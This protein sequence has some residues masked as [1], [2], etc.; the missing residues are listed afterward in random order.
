MSIKQK[1]PMQSDYN[2]DIGGFSKDFGNIE[3]KKIDMFC[4]GVII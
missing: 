3:W 1:R 2:K 4:L